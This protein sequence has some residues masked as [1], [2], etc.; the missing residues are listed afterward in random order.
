M[1]TETASCHCR[2][3]NS[4]VSLTLGE[5]VV[6]P[7]T[8]QDS[9]RC[10]PRKVS[11][12]VFILEQS[13]QAVHVLK[14]LMCVAYV[15]RRRPNNQGRRSRNSRSARGSS[16]SGRG[17]S[18]DS[19]DSLGSGHSPGDASPSFISPVTGEFPSSSQY[20]AAPV[21]RLG[22]S[23]GSSQ[24]SLN[25]GSARAYDASPMLP[26][27]VPPRGHGGPTDFDQ[28]GWPATPPQPYSHATAASASSSTGLYSQYSPYAPP[29]SSRTWDPNFAA[30]YDRQGSMLS[31]SWAPGY[32]NPQDGY[33][34]QD[35]RSHTMAYP[36]VS[37]AAPSTQ[38]A[39]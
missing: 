34:S 2:A 10:L 25:G 33:M 26:I 12:Y 8:S 39:Q 11:E 18:T 14:R 6:L 29:P 20:M 36:S 16:G 35:Q 32:T 24:S 28:G 19:S 9:E 31:R 30:T 13:Y 3:D 4:R 22:S 21:Y 23:L 1:H 37:Y 38:L 5:E 27:S 17:S 15:Y 7:R